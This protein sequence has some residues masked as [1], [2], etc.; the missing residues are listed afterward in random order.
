[1]KKNFF[2]YSIIIFFF[3]FK[4][5]SAENN[6]VYIDLDYILN[7]SLA[8]KS[9][10]TQLNKKKKNLSEKFIKNEKLLKEEEIQLISQK[11]I[12]KKEEFEKKVS[13]LKKK[14]TNFNSE[15]LLLDKELNNKKN[16]AQSVLVKTLTKIV[17]E[18]AEK[19][20]IAIVFPKSNIFLAK[21]ELDITN[22]IIKALNLKL[23][24][25][26]IK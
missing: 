25:I 5:L 7:E 11:N 9:I 12:L 3:L 21:T 6:I 18:Y 15:N 13:I 19:N 14:I 20:S 23:K 22:E 16:K 8:G 10:I 4:N 17:G 24:E 2:G 26:K 1:M